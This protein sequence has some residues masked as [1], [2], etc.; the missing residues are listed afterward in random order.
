MGT[1]KKN[2][3]RVHM[4]GVDTTVRCVTGMVAHFLDADASADRTIP[5]VCS[6]VRVMYN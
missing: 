1:T 2:Q 3:C 4:V 6:T 5:P